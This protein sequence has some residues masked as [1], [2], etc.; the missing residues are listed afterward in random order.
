MGVVV[1]PGEDHTPLL[2]PTYKGRRGIHVRPLV[3][4]V[5]KEGGEAQEEREDP[6]EIPIVRSLQRHDNPHTEH[7]GKTRQAVVPL[8][9]TKSL[10]KIPF[11][12]MWCSRKGSVK[13]GPI[14]GVS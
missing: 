5:G 13:L 7:E 6:E 3:E 14:I 2:E 11:G 1:L 9:S 4:L 12:S 10:P 8:A